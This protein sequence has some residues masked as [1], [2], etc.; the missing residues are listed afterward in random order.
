[1]RSPLQ[2]GIIAPP[3]SDDDETFKEILGDFVEPS[4]AIVKE[5]DDAFEAR[6]A[7]T[8]GAAGHKLKSSSRSVG[9][10]TLADLCAELEK[11]GKGEDW[12]AIEAAMPQLEPSMREVMDYIKAL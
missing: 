4:M 2:W 12:D 1:M 10:N 11:A 6:D 5:I 9:A 7:E 3:F 8:I